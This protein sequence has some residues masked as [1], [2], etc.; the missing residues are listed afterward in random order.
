VFADNY[1]NNKE[2]QKSKE[3]ANSNYSACLKA[4][5]V[6]KA[7]IIISLNN[8]PAYQIQRNMEIFTA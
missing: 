6:Y 1:V 7:V 2:G 4:I 3:K 8:V 5:K